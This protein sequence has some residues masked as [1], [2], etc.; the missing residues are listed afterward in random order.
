MRLAQEVKPITCN[1]DS[2]DDMDTAATTIRVDGAK[3]SSDTQDAN[4]VQVE[5][6]RDGSID[7]GL[8]GQ[9]NI[10]TAGTKECLDKT[11]ERKIQVKDTSCQKC[12][13]SEANHRG[14]RKD[15]WVGCDR[16][17]RWFIEKCVVETMENVD[18]RNRYCY[19]NRERT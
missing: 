4:L 18:I 2:G 5:R 6:N 14:K 9:K 17:D 13:K 12:G 10:R 8:R 7:E 19:G 3:K 11:R 15:K 16:C 1:K